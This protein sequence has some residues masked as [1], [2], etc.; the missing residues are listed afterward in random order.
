VSQGLRQSLV[1]PHR[2]EV[3]LNRVVELLDQALQD[4]TFAGMPLP[5]P[6]FLNALTDAALQ[7]RSVSD[8]IS[9]RQEP[10]P[11]A[12]CGA[13]SPL[14]T[15]LSVKDSSI[16]QTQLIGVLARLQRLS[17]LLTAAEEFYRGWCAAAKFVSYQAHGYPPGLGS[18]W[19][20]T[21]SPALLVLEG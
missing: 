8:C 3:S 4:L 21:P 16:L 20:N 14:I 19:F 12:R 7:L 15:N 5:T 10:L 18:N 13:T 9:D 2:I 17:R 11:T 1:E 6:T